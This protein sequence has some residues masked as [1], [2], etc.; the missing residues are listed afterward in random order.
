[1][2]DGGTHSSGKRQQNDRCGN[3]Q[4]SS[5][6]ALMATWLSGPDPHHGAP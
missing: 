2:F 1:M 6:N 4:T 5:E 3:S